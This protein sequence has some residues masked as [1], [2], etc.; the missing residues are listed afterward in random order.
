MEF[1]EIAKQEAKFAMSNG[2]VPVGAIIVKD[3]I[4]IA[5]AHNLKE[6]LKD[7]TAHAEILAIKQA[8]DYIGDW[9]LTGCEMY[10]TLEPCPM[11]A[12][13]IAQSRISKL[14]IGTFNKDMGAC[15]SVVNL[16]DSI[17]LNYFVSVNWLYDEECS[18]LL[19]KFFDKKRNVNKF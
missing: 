3:G 1:L 16:I 5:K 10:V 19:T 9:R 17:S 14:H 12:S 4:I 18:E 8:S 11:C 15:G 13:A 2:E 7:I 6:K